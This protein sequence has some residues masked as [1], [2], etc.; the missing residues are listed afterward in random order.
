MK[1]QGY[2]IPG[3]VLLALVSTGVAMG[4]PASEIKLAKMA[5]AEAATN[6]AGVTE[7][8]APHAVAELLATALSKVNVDKARL[9]LDEAIAARKAE[10]EG[11]GRTAIYD[12]GVA[13]AQKDHA[14]E[15]AKRTM[16]VQAIA[17]N[18]RNT[19]F[20]LAALTDTQKAAEAAER[21]KRHAAESNLTKLAGVTTNDGAAFAF[22][23]AKLDEV[24]DL[25]GGKRGT[26][27]GLSSITGVGT[28]K[29]KA[30]ST[31]CRSE[32]RTEAW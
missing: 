30:R 6:V 27:A 23:N 15:L 12:L 2:K 32:C 26:I 29:S 1:G 10:A 5:E 19:Q 24:V 18:G 13:A 4:D 11:D 31:A 14:V 8:A 21:T 22:E 20:Q 16:L 25:G 7:G 17:E 9:A 28:K 3:F